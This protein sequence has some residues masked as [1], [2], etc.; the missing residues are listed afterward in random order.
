MKPTLKITD[1]ET[2][3]E[4]HFRDKS[5]H[6]TR[7]LI[8]MAAVIFGSATFLLSWNLQQGMRR[9]DE[10][11]QLIGLAEAQGGNITVARQIY[12]VMQKV[13]KLA[14]LPEDELPVFATIADVTKLQDQA[15]FKQ[16]M[17]GDQILFYLKAQRIFIY[18]PKANFLVAQGPFVLAPQTTEQM[19]ASPIPQNGGQRRPTML[20]QTENSLEPISSLDVSPSAPEASS[21]AQ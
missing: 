11:K 7:I 8:I 2:H 10:M 12:D 1:A 9:Q 17:N 16:A 4:L 20:K 13:S 18:R 3:K 5:V 15:I 19:N 6:I 21:S 14:Q